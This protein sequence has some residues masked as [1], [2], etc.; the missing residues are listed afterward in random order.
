MGVIFPNKR[1]PN[2][3]TKERDP[4]YSLG[5]DFKVSDL[6]VNG[7][8]INLSNSQIY[9]GASDGNILVWN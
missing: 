5:P 1:D 4:K 7:L 3:N 9:T 2:E 6:A 8:G